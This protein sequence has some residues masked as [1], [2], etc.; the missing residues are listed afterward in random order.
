MSSGRLT[1]AIEGIQDQFLTGNPEVSYFLKRFTKQTVFAMETLNNVFDNGST[2]GDTL[3]CTIPRKGQLIKSIYFRAKLPALTSN[4]S[5]A[6]GQYIGYTDSV[7]AVMIDYAD[8]LIGGQLI[9]RIN[10]EYISIFNEL[11]QSDSQQTSIKWLTGKTKKHDGLKLAT[12]NTSAVASDIPYGVYPREFL[13]PLPFYFIYSDPLAIP[14]VALTKQE[15]EVVIKLRPIEQ[16]MIG[17]TEGTAPPTNAD[18]ALIFDPRP[19]LEL[20]SLPVEYVFLGNDEIEKIQN[21]QKDYIITQLQMQQTHVEPNVSAA[22]LRLNFI[23]PVKEM[24]FIIQ[25][26]IETGP[27]YNQWTQW[28]NQQQTASPKFTQ[29]ESMELTFNNEVRISADVADSLF[30]NWI[31]PLNNHTR[32]GSTPTNH[33]IG[34][35]YNYSFSLDPENYLPTGQVNMSRIINKNLTM[36]LTPNTDSEGRDIRVYAK[37]YNV[38]RF[39][40]G[41]A[42]LLFIENNHF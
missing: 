16:M 22:Q 17:K 30:L 36:N 20:V 34:P 13:V 8:L 4:T 28:K 23:N 12:S 32:S 24:F 37:S 35:I 29:V 14:L 7:G 15:V 9:E 38:L 41:L 39:A 10:G 33:V 26:T 2:W 19:G 3:R 11:F 25:N 18:D 42:G 31:Q 21:T 6:L 40:N 27:N 5:N 1:L